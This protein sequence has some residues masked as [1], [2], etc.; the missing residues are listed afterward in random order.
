MGVVGGTS[1]VFP[2]KRESTFPRGE[3]YSTVPLTLPS[4]LGKVA[5]LKVGFADER[6]QRLR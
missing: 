5:E 2:L 4:P 1:S 3:G 6:C